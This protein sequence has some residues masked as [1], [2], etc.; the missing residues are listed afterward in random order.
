MAFGL[1][2]KDPISLI[3]ILS[4]FAKNKGDFKFL[5]GLVEDKIVSPEQI[6][7]LALI[8][9]REELIAKLIYL[10]KDIIQGK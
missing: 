8:P 2:Y 6:K 10:I 4:K 5:G 1:G 9:S 3:K 7:V